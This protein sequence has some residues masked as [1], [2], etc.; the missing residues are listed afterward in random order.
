VH[1]KKVALFEFQICRV[2]LVPRVQNTE[3]SKIPIQDS[4]NNS[5][6]KVQSN[7]CNVKKI[8]FKKN[9]KRDLKMTAL[10]VIYKNTK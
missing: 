10:I 2:L 1:V 8:V 9:E 7:A 5:C 3:M 6:E 4:R